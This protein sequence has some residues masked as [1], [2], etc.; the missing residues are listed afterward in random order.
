VD[1]AFKERFRSVLRRDL[2]SAEAKRCGSL[3][4]PL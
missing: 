4:W 2:K 3:W 1:E